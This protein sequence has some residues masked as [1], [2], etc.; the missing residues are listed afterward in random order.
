MSESTPHFTISQHS[1]AWNMCL[2]LLLD[3]S[4]SE[5]EA[6]GPDQFFIKKN[7]ESIHVEDI[8]LPD[9]DAYYE[10][11]IQGLINET[12]EGKPLVRSAEPFT[13]DKALFEGILE[14]TVGVNKK[15]RVR[16]RAHIVLPPAATYAPNITIAKKTASLK[17]LES[18]AAQ[19]SMSTEMKNFLNACV[20]NDLTIVF[21]GST[22]AGKT[23]MMEALSKEVDHKTRIGVAEDLPE[24]ELTQPN[25]AYLQSVPLSPG[26]DAKNVVTLEWN[27]QQTQRMR[28]DKIFVG[29]IRGKEFASFLIAANSGMEG[30]MTTMHANNPR[31][32][33]V[34]MSQFATAGLPSTPLR[35]VNQ[36]IATSVD[37]IVQL[38]KHRGRY[39]VSHIEEI[40]RTVGSGEEAKISSGTLYEWDPVEDKFFKAGKMSDDLR[41]RFEIKGADISEFLANNSGNKYD[42]HM[43]RPDI[44]QAPAVNPF[45]RRDPMG[46]A[47]TI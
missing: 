16:A 9:E 44:K 43:S 39:R 47:R 40:S 38:T 3:P 8:K 7:G 20:K 22:G 35:M 15:T 19:G 10:D 36:S 2:N 1:S 41:R 6:N 21:S 26:M 23:T 28:I 37:V 46:G 31:E 24:L 13:K 5:V 42:A 32:C 18:I 25:V 30:S 17:T 12:Y 4:V 34:K 33:L 29:E 27:I 45:S 14:Y 11:L